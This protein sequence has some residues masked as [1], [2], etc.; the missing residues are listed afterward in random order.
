MVRTFRTD[1]V[2]GGTAAF[3]ANVSQVLI[4]FVM[5]YIINFA[6]REYYAESRG[7]S[8]P[9]IGEGVGLVLA[10]VIM[11]IMSS[12]GN[13]HFFYRGMILGGQLRSAL[14]SLI[15]DKAMSISGRAKAGRSPLAP[16][17]EGVKPESDEEKEHYQHQLQTDGNE[18][19]MKKGAKPAEG[20]NNG[21]IVNLMS[22]DTYRIDQASGWLHLVWTSPLSTIITIVLLLI[23]LTY[24]AV[25]GIVLFFLSVPIMAFCARAMFKRRKAINKLTDQRVSMMQEILQSIRFVKYYAWEGY[26]MK[27]LGQIR[28]REIHSVRLLL[29]TRNAITVVGSGILIL[30]SMLTFIT[31]SLTNHALEPGPVF[32]SLALFNQLRMPLAI[33]PMVIG[34]VMDALQSIA[35]IEKFL[36]AEDAPDVM[37]VENGAGI[38]LDLRDA[39]FTW[40]QSSPSDPTEG[41]AN[42]AGRVA[43]LREAKIKEKEAKVERKK[44]A[45]EIKKQREAGAGS[46]G[47]VT[48]P[49]GPTPEATPFTLNDINLQVR[50][51][52]LIAVIGG[53]GSGKSSLLSAIVGDMRRTA[54]SS[55]LNGKVALCAQL[56]WIQNATVRDNITFGGEYNAIKYN[57]VIEA[58]ALDHDVKILPHGS[59]TEIGERGINLSGGQKHRVSLARAIYF[60]ADVILLDDPLAAVDA[61]VGAHI[62][63]NAICG[64]LKDK[65]R[66]LATHQL[67]V[68]PRCDR[69]IMMGEGRIVA[70]GT[71]EELIAEN[72]AFQALMTSIDRDERSRSE[73]QND[74][75]PEHVVEHT[76]TELDQISLMQQEERQVHGIK[77]SVYANFWRSSGSLLVPILI[78]LCLAVAQG[79][80]IFTNLWLAWW[81][82]NKFHMATG[83]YVSFIVPPFS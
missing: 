17:Q 53:V 19:E 34:L 62:M 50:P 30:A 83:V 38:A 42:G 3:V 11:Q 28:Q 55:T 39:S 58:C 10:M 70:C 1:L 36:L 66:V 40:E 78:I 71:F 73:N 22:V 23:N 5:K 72:E 37:S 76:P 47:E 56:A 63:E 16:P 77:W 49:S 15:F 52:E 33:Y 59:S 8:A 44:K 4:P 12:I 20:W 7:V 57:R 32:S 25:V 46:A 80:N 45:K 81:S 54:G 2:I 67:H 27:R 29:T 75:K 21:R 60:D 6:V 14:I 31:F 48:E 69:I 9:A 41:V 74:T 82:D 35:R 26:F 65:C 43:N 13:N 68:L 79:A 24:S 64:L 51:G 61:H 18:K